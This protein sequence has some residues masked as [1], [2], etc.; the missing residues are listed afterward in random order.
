MLLYSKL[1]LLDH[2][3]QVMKFTGVYTRDRNRIGHLL[4]LKTSVL[5]VNV[6][7]S[8]RLNY[9]NSLFASVSDFESRRLNPKLTAGLSLI[10]PSFSISFP[11]QLKK[12]HWVPV[13][14]GV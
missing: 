2:E 11:A 8:S 4:D 12:L 6:L 10:L 3:S 9:C 13:K 5:P 1:S 7:V 14:Y